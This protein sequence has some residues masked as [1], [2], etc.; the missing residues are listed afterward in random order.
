M[1]MN[2]DKVVD[3]NEALKAENEVLKAKNKELEIQCQ[4]L[5]DSLESSEK[6]EQLL[7]RVGGKLKAQLA[8]KTEELAAAVNTLARFPNTYALTDG[9]VEK[10]AEKGDDNVGIF[11]GVKRISIPHPCPHTVS[12]DK[13]RKLT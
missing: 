10:S 7:R 8:D 9:E 2:A 11:G 13:K 5:N 6:L 1:M 3:E 4:E 12:T